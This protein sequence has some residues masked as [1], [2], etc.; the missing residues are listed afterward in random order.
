MFYQK[1]SLIFFLLRVSLPGVLTLPHQQQQ[2]Q[3]QQPDNSYSEYLR[4]LSSSRWSITFAPSKRITTTATTTTTT[5]AQL[6]KQEKLVEEK[7]SSLIP[8]LIQLCKDSIE[9]SNVLQQIVCWALLA[10]YIMLIV[11]LVLHQLCSIFTL[12]R[13]G[14]HSDKQNIESKSHNRTNF[15]GMLRV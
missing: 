8:P 3:Q 10:L 9:E 5:P 7:V 1:F 15:S 4:K 14:Q 2:Q 12:K 6:I 13:N 11:S